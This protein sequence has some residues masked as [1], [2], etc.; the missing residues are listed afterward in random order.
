MSEL[1]DDETA[2]FVERMMRDVIEG[3]KPE[4]V[5]ETVAKAIYEAR[6]GRGC[7]PWSIQPSS[8][9]EPYLTDA[10]AAIDAYQDYIRR[11]S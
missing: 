5:A 9:R 4:I 6:N 8:D 3:K 11:H 2:E 10:R 7:K 1:D